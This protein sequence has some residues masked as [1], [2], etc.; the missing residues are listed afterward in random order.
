MDE[1]DI[2]QQNDE[3]FRQ[4]ALINHFRR[5]NQVS[6]EAPPESAHRCCRDCGEEIEPERLEA[7]PGAAR[8][9]EC[10][11]RFERRNR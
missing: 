6:Q 3:L 9:I 10:Q 2:A 4:N 11:G 8:C 5:R 7:V 1:I